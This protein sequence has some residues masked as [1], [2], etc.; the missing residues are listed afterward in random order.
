MPAS[1]IWRWPVCNTIERAKHLHRLYAAIYPDFRPV[2]V[3]SQ[4]SL[5]ERRENLA[6]LRRLRAGSSFAS[7]CSARAS[8]CPS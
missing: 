3:H 2:I 5:K 6:A 8:T 4:Q 7:I 1:I